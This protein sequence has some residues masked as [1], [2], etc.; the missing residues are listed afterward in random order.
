MLTLKPRR[1]KLFPKIYLR[2][3]GNYLFEKHE[4]NLFYT[5]VA[6]IKSYGCSGIN[7]GKRMT[8]CTLN[9]WSENNS[10]KAH[11]QIWV[12]QI[13]GFLGDSVVKNTPCNARDMGSIPCRGTKMPHA[14]E[15]LSPH[16]NSWAWVLQLKS[17]C[18]LGRGSHMMQWRSQV[19]Q[20]TQDAN[21]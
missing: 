21:K 20:L 5:T 4:L 19:L 2:V 16:H 15:Q 18:A 7:N 12:K 1:K 3:D 8:C 10:L 14:A 9:C 6:K 11:G 17:L 13:G